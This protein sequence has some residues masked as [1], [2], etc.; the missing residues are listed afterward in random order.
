L[1]LT[2]LG[3]SLTAGTVTLINQSSETL[4]VDKLES[5]ADPRLG[6]NPAKTSW[7]RAFLAPYSTATLDLPAQGT[8]RFM[9]SRAKGSQQVWLEVRD[10]VETTLQPMMSASL[11]WGGM[12]QFVQQTAQGTVTF[13]A[14]LRNHPMATPDPLPAAGAVPA[15]AR[16]LPARNLAAA[17][18]ELKEPAAVAAPQNA[19]AAAQDCKSAFP[20]VA[21]SKQNTAK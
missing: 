6:T 20:S 5:L 9:V 15:L 21:P 13:L 4:F 12:N 7:D 10:G 1:A 16:P 14:G 11:L 18:Q 2:A 19:P 17:F 8:Y 3:S